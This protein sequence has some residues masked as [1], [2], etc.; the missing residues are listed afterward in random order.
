MII[1]QEHSLLLLVSLVSCIHCGHNNFEAV[2][3]IYLGVVW[4]L[5]VL[6]LFLPSVSI[7]VVLGVTVILVCVL[8][9]LSTSAFSYLAPMTSGVTVVL[10]SLSEQWAFRYLTPTLF[11]SKTIWSQLRVLFKD[12]T[13]NWTNEQNSVILR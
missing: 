9:P 5:L 13:G 2:S 3:I 8:H 11:T 1:L 6:L 10:Y 12:K 7:N 4:D